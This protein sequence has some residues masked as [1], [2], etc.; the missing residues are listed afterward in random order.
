M[1]TDQK[2]LSITSLQTILQDDT[3]FNVKVS[4]TDFFYLLD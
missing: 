1:K 4:M 2:Q 3:S